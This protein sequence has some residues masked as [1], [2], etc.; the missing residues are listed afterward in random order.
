MLLDCP[1]CRGC[2]LQDRTYEFLA[3]RCINCGTVLD[4]V[5]LENSARQPKVIQVEQDFPIDIDGEADPP[6][7][8][9]SSAWIWA[10]QVD[11]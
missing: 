4:P 11:H 1:R 3:F 2:L 9:D 6:Q 10:D 8:Y 5:I 7:D